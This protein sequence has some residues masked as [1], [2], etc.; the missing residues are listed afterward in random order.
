MRH[1]PSYVPAES[2]Y[3]PG[4][5]TYRRRGAT[6]AVRILLA[7][8]VAAAVVALAVLIGTAYAGAHPRPAGPFVTPTTY[9]APGPT[10]G[11]Q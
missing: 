3:V 4:P 10:G 6:R 1:R 8:I 5:R 9:G 2:R 7:V 11:P